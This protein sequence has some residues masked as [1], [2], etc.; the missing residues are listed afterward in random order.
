[1]H[2]N[3]LSQ[4]LKAALLMTAATSLFVTAYADESITDTASDEVKA[5]AKKALNLGSMVVTASG[6][7]QEVK[8][9]PA[10]ISVISQETIS[11]KPFNNIGD[12][13]RDVEGVNVSRGGKSGGANIGIRGMG[14]DYTLLMVDGQ[15]VSQNS[16]GARPNGF[17]D[18]DSAFIPPSSAIERIEVVRGPMSTLYG[19]DALGGVINVITKKVPEQWGG[20]VSFSIEE[21]TNS[22][23]SGGNTTSVYLGG[24]IQ[25]DLIGLALMGSFQTKRNAKGTY[26]KNSAGELGK[27]ANF[28]GLGERKNF[29][30][31]AR[32]TFTP[33][34][35]EFVVSYDR[36][37]QRYENDDN[38]LG[39]QNSTLK[40]GKTGGGYADH[41]RFT[42]E[43]IGI[44]HRAELDFATVESGLLWDE[45][46]TVGRLNPVN[47]KPSARAGMDRDIKYS[48]II[49]DHKWMFGLGDHFISAGLQ[50]KDQK[51]KDTLEGSELDIKQW[52]W[53]LFAEDEWAINDDL[54]ATFG[55]RYDKNED[56]GSHFSPRAYLVWNIDDNW[57]VKGGVSRAFKAP[58][59]QKMTD[60]VIGLGRQGALPLLG[61]PDLKPET[62]TSG[63]LGFS[64]S[65]LDDFSFNTTAF[66]TSFKD[67]IESVSQANCRLDPSAGCITINGD[68]KGSKTFSKQFNVDDAKLYGLEMGAKYQALE[69]VGLS[70]SYTYTHSNY[71]NKDGQ[72][73][74]FS[75]TP[76]HMLNLKADWNIN[77]QWIVWA[78]GE[79]RAKEYDDLNWNKDKVYYRS[80]ALVNLG[81]SFKPS[82]DMAINFGVDNIFDKNFIDYTYA[83]T[84]TAAPGAGDAFSNRYARLEE[85]RKLWL[86]LNY[87]F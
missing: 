17:G 64:Y 72:K 46:K 69:N 87:E 5:E 48:N 86:K 44:T 28:S 16:S 73:I 24:P 9:A 39:T 31:G 58:D 55:L 47:A 25:T 74:P 67:K 77:G 62:A 32:L 35:Q 81:A 84:G 23:F 65:N 3:I 19:S 11:Q 42:R 78:E 37:V 21:P 45:T 22:K 30:Y 18:V 51:F 34:N 80:Y 12:V 29:N 68:D 41:L 33:E 40:P 83:Q 2:R 20:Q 7:A 52:Q 61:N 59:I 54:I 26:V 82:R 66:Y 85:G 15:R 8:D 13:L 71:K 75:K 70:A 76:Q 57:Q 50:Y 56:F 49:F 60:G 79:Y 53:A 14:S 4:K 27:I 38:Q 36:G 10:S 1:M 43:R 6:F 63:E